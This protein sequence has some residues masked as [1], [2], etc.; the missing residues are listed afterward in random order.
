M[1]Q[2]YFRGLCQPTAVIR[3]ALRIFFKKQAYL[4]K[5]YSNTHS[6]EKEKGKRE[7]KLICNKTI[8][9]YLAL[10]QRIMHTSKLKNI[11]IRLKP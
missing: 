5:T 10:E 8:D 3:L 7:W 1:S 6:L 2:L 9:T 4:L 11:K